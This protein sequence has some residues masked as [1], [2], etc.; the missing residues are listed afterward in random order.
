MAV[1][2]QLKKDL[3]LTVRSGQNTPVARPDTAPVVS[4][5]KQSGLMLKVRLGDEA[6]PTR[7]G[8]PEGVAFASVMTFVGDHPAADPAEWVFRGNSSR[9][10]LTMSFPVDTPPGSTVWV[11]AMWSNAK[12]QSGPVS[13]PLPVRIAGV[14]G[15]VAVNTAT[16]TE[17]MKIAA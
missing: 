10:V 5:V 9:N 13:S 16:K 8:R 2:D 15:T 14:V 7:R 6:D 3:G 1:S 11:C 4:V 12:T 17:G